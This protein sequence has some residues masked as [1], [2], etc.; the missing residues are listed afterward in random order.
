MLEEFGHPTVRSHPGT[1]NGYIHSIGH[2][3]GIEIHES[4][5]FSLNNNDDVLKVGNVITIEPGV[6]YP[7][8][9]FG[10]RVEDTIYAAEDGTFHS[11]TPMTKDLVLP[12][13]G[14]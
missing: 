13:K 14:E 3:V 9:G 7:E 5:R 6:Y 11:L 12:L 2:G 10:I 8:K 1:T 4:P